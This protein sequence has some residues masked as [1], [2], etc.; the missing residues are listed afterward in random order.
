[1]KE[2][3]FQGSVALFMPAFNEVG[4]LGETVRRSVKF[5]SER[6]QPFKVII[7]N[8]GSTD[9][10]T[11]LAEELANEFPDQVF[12]VHHAHNKGYGAALRTGF[13][14]ALATGYDYIAFCDSD[15]QFHPS[16]LDALFVCMEENFSDVAIGY[17]EERADGFVRLMTGKVWHHSCSLLLGL[18]VR[19]VDCG[20][21][22]FRRGVVESVFAGPS[23]LQGDY[24]TI[25]PEMLARVKRGGYT[26]GQVGL[27]HFPREAGKPSGVKLK[28]I[29]GSY[30]GLLSLRRSLE[31]I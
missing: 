15:G 11:S 27:N 26:I 12:V 20:F 6:E 29:F 9:G 23:G 25:N 31:Q 16:S 22:L 21:K 18:Q 10:T 3:R 30:K 5:L 17:R 28:V 7:V 8:D 19:D 1:M 4:V 14:E 2:E 13:R 24:A